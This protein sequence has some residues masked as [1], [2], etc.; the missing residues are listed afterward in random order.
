MS[1]ARSLASERG[2]EPR[3]LAAPRGAFAENR[4]QAD[5]EREEEEREE[6][7]ALTRL[8][9]EHA[10]RKAKDAFTHAEPPTQEGAFAHMPSPLQEPLRRVT[11]WVA[12]EM[13]HASFAAYCSVDKNAKM[14]QIEDL[15]KKEGS[16]AWSRYWPIMQKCKN[17]GQWKG[18][19]N[20]D[21]VAIPIE[22]TMA[23]RTPED[24]GRS[25][26]VKWMSE[27]D[28]VVCATLKSKE[29]WITPELLTWMEAT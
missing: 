1:S 14:K 6:R 7:I 10:A 20:A 2:G 24:V 28:G 15:L 4:E 19:A 3:R 26:L 27:F 25:L 5:K 21:S 11:E 17:L 13:T 22:A 23:M 16:V 18:R 12:C 9:A 29:H 8:E